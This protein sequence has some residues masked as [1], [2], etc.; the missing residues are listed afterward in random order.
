[1][2][3]NKTSLV[4]NTRS[5]RQSMTKEELHLWCDCLKELSVKVKRQKQFG[6]YI[7]DFYI[8]DKKLAIEIDG[9]QHYS[10]HGSKY[11]K[12]RTNFLNELGIEVVRYSNL[13]V[14]QNFDDVCTDI[15][16]RVTDRHNPSP[17]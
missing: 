10:D 9:S 6:N 13:D 12:E 15:M 4:T 8:P 5:L 11:D 3:I 7:V 1:M 17:D 14:M 16:N 2:K